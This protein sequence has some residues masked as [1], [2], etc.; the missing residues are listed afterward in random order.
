MM[1]KRQ[2]RV[3]FAGE[4]WFTHR[5]H[6]KGFDSFEDSSYHEGG[7]E[8]IEALRQGGVEVTYQPSHIAADRFPFA[9]DELRA[10]DVVILSDIGANTLLLPQ[11]TFASSH[12]SANRLDLLKTFVEGGGGLLMIGGYLTFQ[13]IQAKGAWR[14][15]PVEAVLP[16]SL[17]PFDDRR[18]QPQG[19]TPTILE[20]DHPVMRG[21]EAWPQFLGYNRATLQADAVALA[22]VGEDPFIAVRSVGEGRTA[23]FAS[24]CGPHWGPPAFLAWPGYGR[25]WTNLVEWLAKSDEGG[26]GA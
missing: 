25:L 24:D 12:A 5:I 26:R 20:T 7:A 22:S 1:S 11:R 19:V 9:L 8:L 18:E 3:L 4:S 15:T 10:Y 13:G 16:V 2:L 17:S 14:D 21:L 6:V 23:I